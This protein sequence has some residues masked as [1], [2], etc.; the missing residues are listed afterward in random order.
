MHD[1]ISLFRLVHCIY[2]V[3]QA[4]KALNTVDAVDE[5]D[6]IDTLP[7]YI[8]QVLGA[9]VACTIVQAHSDVELRIASVQVDHQISRLLM[10]KLL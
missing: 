8:Q 3:L 1:F 10:H 2:P 5:N 9:I 4:I 6:R 7:V